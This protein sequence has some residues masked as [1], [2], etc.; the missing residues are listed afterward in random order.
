MGELAYSV[1]QFDFRRKISGK[2]L[3]FMKIRQV[4]AQLFRA[5]RQT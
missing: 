1:C 4:G 3:N 5:D 2:I